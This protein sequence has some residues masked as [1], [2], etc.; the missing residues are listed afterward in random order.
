MQPQKH[1]LGKNQAFMNIVS[2]QLENTFLFQALKTALPVSTAILTKRLL[3]CWHADVLD[4]RLI[5]HYFCLKVSS[6]NFHLKP[7]LK[8]AFTVACDVSTLYN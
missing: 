6:K 8:I 7:P 4:G 5:T 3:P 2:K 1:S